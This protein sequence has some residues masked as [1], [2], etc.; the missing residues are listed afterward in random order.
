MQTLEHRFSRDGDSSTA[1]LFD[2]IPAG[3]TPVKRVEKYKRPVQADDCP[4]CEL[5]KT[6][7][8]T[9]YW[10]GSIAALQK[11][12]LLGC[13]RCSLLQKC[14]IRFTDGVDCTQS[15]FRAWANFSLVELRLYDHG[16]HEAV[17]RSLRLDVF[18]GD[19]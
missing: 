5:P 17:E 2:P 3:I 16:A 7:S 9:T 13:I 14:V 8:D 15:R 6:S 19:G 11:A 18:V 4:C 12:S 1:D 10:D